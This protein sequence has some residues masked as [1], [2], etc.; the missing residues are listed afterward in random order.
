ME[1]IITKYREPGGMGWGWVQIILPC[2]P[3]PFYRTRCKLVTTLFTVRGLQLLLLLLLLLLTLIWCTWFG[4]GLLPATKWHPFLS[5]SSH[6]VLLSSHF[7]LS[8]L[9]RRFIYRLA[10]RHWCA[11]KMRS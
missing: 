2:H 9:R 7:R 10:M 6:F 11:L 4:G 1:R 5:C 3:L 8:R